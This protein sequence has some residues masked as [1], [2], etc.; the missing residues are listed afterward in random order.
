[1][2]KDAAIRSGGRITPRGGD[3]IPKTSGSGAVEKLFQ[4]EV[5]R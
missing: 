3:E 5:I 4:V 2:D 1:M